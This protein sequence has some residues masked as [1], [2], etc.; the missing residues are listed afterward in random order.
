MCNL[1]FFTAEYTWCLN[2][3]FRIAMFFV[4]MLRTVQLLKVMR[5][6]V[7]IIVHVIQKIKLRK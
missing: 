7:R 3:F 2:K 1:G 5:C 4:S 6:N